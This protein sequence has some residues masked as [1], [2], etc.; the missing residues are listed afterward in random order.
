[1][2]GRGDN[3]GVDGFPGQ[4][5]VVIGVGLGAAAGTLDGALD[6][7]SIAV[8]HSDDFRSGQRLHGLHQ[9]LAARPGTNESNLNAIVR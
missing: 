1:M 2:V 9:F 6:A 4:Q 5:L 7:A 8:H 3:Y